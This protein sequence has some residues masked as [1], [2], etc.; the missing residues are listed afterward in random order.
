LT[1]A[2]SALDP[3]P[4]CLLTISPSLVPSPDLA[5]ALSQS[6]RQCLSFPLYRSFSLAEACRTD[7]AELFLLGKRTLVRCLLETKDIV[8]HHEVYYV[9]SKIWLEDFCVWVQ[10]YTT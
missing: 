7:V 3:A 5:S 8:E 2:F 9:Y 6:Y 10:A 1:P 4:Y